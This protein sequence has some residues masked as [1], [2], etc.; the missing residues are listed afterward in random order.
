MYARVP[1]TSAVKIE[2]REL[3]ILATGQVAEVS[4]IAAASNLL[5]HY[6]RQ[7]ESTTLQSHP[8]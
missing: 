3:V 4:D 5:S 1:T 2:A 7:L 8:T 6:R